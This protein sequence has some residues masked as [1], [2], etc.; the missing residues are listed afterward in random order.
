MSLARRMRMA[1]RVL[2]SEADR[3]SRMRKRVSDR[4]TLNEL[5]STPEKF[6]MADTPIITTPNVADERWFLG[7]DFGPKYSNLIFSDGHKIISSTGT[8]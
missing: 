8:A 7:A 5:M 2:S 3:N 6:W 1:Y 4:M